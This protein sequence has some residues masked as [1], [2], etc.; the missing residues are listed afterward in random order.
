MS[1]II[2]DIREHAFIPERLAGL[3]MFRVP[4]SVGLEVLVSQE[5][6]DLF[7]GHN[8]TG[9]RFTLLWDSDDNP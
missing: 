3:H 8:L 7:E 9:A 4:E 6:K 5:F 2:A 1:G